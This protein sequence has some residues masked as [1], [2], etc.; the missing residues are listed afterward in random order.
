MN[1]II[2]MGIIPKSLYKSI[3]FTMAIC[4]YIQMQYNIIVNHAASSLLNSLKCLYIYI[5]I[6]IWLSYKGPFPN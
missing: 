4:D 5:Y 2:H 1:I 3:K 6:Y